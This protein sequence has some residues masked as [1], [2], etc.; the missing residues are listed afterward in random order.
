M[1]ENL[2]D[3]VGVKNCQDSKYEHLIILLLRFTSNLRYSK[4]L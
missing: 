1:Y 4:I 2:K 3:I